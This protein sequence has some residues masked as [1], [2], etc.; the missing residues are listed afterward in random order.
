MQRTRDAL[1]YCVPFLLIL[2]AWQLFRTFEIIPPWILPSPSETAIAFGSLVLDGTMLRLVATSAGHMIPAFV[3]SSITA[4][5]V[6]L[7][8]GLSSTWRKMLMPMLSVIYIVPTLAWLPLI[9]LFLGFTRSSIFVIVFLATFPKVVYPAIAGVQSINRT[10]ILAGRNLGLTSFG[11]ILK[12]VLPGAL[13]YLVVG[14]RLGFGSA[15]RSLIGAEMLVASLGGLGRF[16][17]LAQWNYSF[18]RVLAGITVM[19]IVGLV[20]EQWLFR[21]AEDWVNARWNTV[22]GELAL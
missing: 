16:I 22:S 11:V 4:I 18:D 12:I 3:L 14:A 10:W 13:P 15:W 1:L 5:F 2:I 17:W 8:V 9:V 6:G 7:L 19:I 20:A 21:R